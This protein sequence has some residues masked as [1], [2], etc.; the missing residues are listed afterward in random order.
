M[1]LHVPILYGEF[2]ME[3]FCR[4]HVKDLY[5][6]FLSRLFC[7]ISKKINFCGLLSQEAGLKKPAC[8]CPL[9]QKTRAIWKD[10]ERR[11]VRDE[12]NEKCGVCI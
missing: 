7:L 5:T 3:F 11:R 4:E 8:K 1:E 12:E 10:R 9:K 6:G 2:F